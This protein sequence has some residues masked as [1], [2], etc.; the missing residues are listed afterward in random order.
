MWSEGLG[1]ED[2][3][4]DAWDKNSCD[5]TGAFSVIMKEGPLLLMSREFKLS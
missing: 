4:T 1:D 3:F 5:Q 2:I